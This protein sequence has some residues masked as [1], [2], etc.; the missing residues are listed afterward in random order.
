MPSDMEF[1][2]RH[3]VSTFFSCEDNIRLKKGESGCLPS[4]IAILECKACNRSLRDGEFQ[5]KLE[6]SSFNK[7]AL[8]LF[9]SLLISTNN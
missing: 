8:T 7:F 6:C 3:L 5:F 9:C 4:V 2:V 1:M